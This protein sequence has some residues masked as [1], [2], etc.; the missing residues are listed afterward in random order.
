MR[1][2]RY[3]PAMLGFLILAIPVFSESRILSIEHAVDLALENNLTLHSRIIGLEMKKR[4]SASNWNSYIPSMSARTSLGYT[5]SGTFGDFSPFWGLSFGLSGSLSISKAAKLRARESLLAYEKEKISFE[6]AARS[7]ERDIRANF[8]GL[9]LSESRI[10]LMAQNVESALQRLKAAEEDYEI[11]YI[12]ELEVLN[13]RLT[14]QQMEASL[15]RTVAAY[16]TML[17]EFKQSIGVDIGEPIKLEGTIIVEGAKLDQNGLIREFIDSG[18]AIQVL[19]K[20]KEILQ[21]DVEQTFSENFLPNLSFSYSFTPSLDEPFSNS[22]IRNESWSK[23]NSL[24]M[25]MSI[26]LDSLYR[27]SA[28]RIQIKNINDSVAINELEIRNAQE[29]AEI[30][31]RAMVS[32]INS[33]LRTLEVLQR[34]VELSEKVFELTQKEYEAGLADYLDLDQANYDLQDARLDLLSESY[35]YQVA[36]LDLRFMLDLPFDGL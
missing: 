31:L 1:L 25:S 26:P 4:Q 36:L 9:I 35:N 30:E 17:M 20:E 3:V 2:M 24:N 32:G 19:L 27:G 18:T 10:E 14:L 12:T 21:N 33:L 5:N 16:E 13:N 6:A 15:E 22:W 34:T 29:Q 7:L 8:Y 23:R 11:G 28:G